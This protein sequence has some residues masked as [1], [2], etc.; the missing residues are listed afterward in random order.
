MIPLVLRRYLGAVE[1]GRLDD[2]VSL[3]APDGLSALPSTGAHEETAPLRQA[4]D[5]EQLKQILPGSFGDGPITVLMTAGNGDGHWF[6]EGRI[7]SD[8][9][10]TLIASFTV[11]GDAIRRQLVFRCQ[12]V[13]PPPAGGSVANHDGRAAV[14]RYFEALETA[15][16][17]AAVACFS[18]DTLYSHP[19]YKHAPEEGRAEFRGRAELL[20]GFERRGYRTVHH[21]LL[22]H[23]QD[24]AAFLV[25]GGTDDEPGGGSFMSSVTLDGDGRIRRYVALFTQP[26]VPF[27]TGR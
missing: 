25:E 13:D 12:L 27:L 8:P 24:G 10:E 18:R 15:D 5:R 2:A 23:A 4:G 14:E 20:A 3:I 22:A 17:P 7:E 19:P 21:Q 16:M 1:G 6:V 9:A 11:D 26:R